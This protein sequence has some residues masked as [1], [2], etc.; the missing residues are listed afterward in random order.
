MPIVTKQKGKN[1]PLFSFKSPEQIEIFV[2]L[3]HPVFK[4]FHLKPEQF[5]ASEVALVLFDANRR[6]SG[7]QHL[8]LHTLST[9]AWAIL[10]NRW[11]GILEDNS[12]KVKGDVVA[13][14]DNVREKLVEVLGEKAG[15]IYDEL[16]DRQIK[17]VVNN[18]QARGL[19]V[20]K[21][22]EMRASGQYFLYIDEATIIEL[23]KNYTASFFDG[24][25]W[26]VSYEQITDL[27]DSVVEDIRKNTSSVYLNCLEDVV[28]YLSR[29]Q[30]DPI[31]LQRA[32]ASL[33]F[34][35]QKFI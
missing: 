28:G 13:F 18:L 10:Q 4:S 31:I 24:K 35:Q 17:A 22:Q 29:K 34:L 15:D 5:I 27:P 6:L 14:F 9:L 30:P 12:E 2:D 33:Q 26:N 11:Q 32:R 20:R 25:L 8:G 1:I 21:I 3:N 19:D 23:F 7:S 16:D